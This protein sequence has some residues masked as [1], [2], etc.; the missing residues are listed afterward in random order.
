MLIEVNGGGE[1]TVSELPADRRAI[2]IGDY[3]ADD[4]KIAAE[5]G[6]APTRSLRETLAETL[7][8]YRR[9]RVAYV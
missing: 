5:L 6:W 4:S 8:Y 3:H 9:H 7:E 2:D 1:A